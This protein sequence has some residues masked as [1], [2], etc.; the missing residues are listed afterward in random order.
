MTSETAQSTS[1]DALS[2]TNHYNWTV[3]NNVTGTAFSKL[4]DSPT[5][6]PGGNAESYELKLWLLVITI[7]V[8]LVLVIALTFTICFCIKKCNGG[9]RNVA[10]DTSIVMPLRRHLPTLPWQ[11]AP[12]PAGSAAA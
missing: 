10:V 1:D 7:A 9:L 11:S 4:T 5:T 2:S 12:L 6:T 3:L 8:C